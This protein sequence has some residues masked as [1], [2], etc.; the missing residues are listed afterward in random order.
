MILAPYWVSYPEMVRMVYGEPVIVTPEDGSFVPRLEE[1]EAAF[2]SLHEGA[3]RQQ[4]EQP[5]RRGLPGVAHRGLVELCEKRG[6]TLL[7]DDIYH[8]LVFDGVR[9]PSAYAFTDRD[10]DDVAR[11][12]RQRRLEALRHDRLPHRLGGRRRGRSSRR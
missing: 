10:V 8:R 2:G 3:H 6:I 12:R 7:M 5:V 11:H 9:P 4:P 1:V